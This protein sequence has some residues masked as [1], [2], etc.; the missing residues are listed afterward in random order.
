[1]ISFD[2]VFENADRYLAPVWRERLEYELK[3]LMAERR[4]G[5]LADWL[6]ALEATPAIRPQT[7]S[8][9]TPTVTLGTA[10]E[11][12]ESEKSQIAT[13][14]LAL[15]PWRKGPYSCFGNHIDTEWR[16]DWKWERVQPHIRPLDGRVVLDI[17]CG[18]GYHCWRMLGDGAR[19]VLGVDPSQLF[20]MQFRMIRHFAGDHPI[21]IVPLGIEHLPR[22]KPIFDTV[23]SMGVLYHRRSPIDHLLELRDFL[24]PGGELVLETLVIEDQDGMTLVPQDRYAQMRN[25]WFIPSCPTMETW[26]HRAG[27]TDIKLRDV[28]ITTT[29]EQRSTDWMT[30]QSL[31][32]FLDPTD[33]HKTIEGYP[34]PT[35][36]IW[37]A[38]RP[39]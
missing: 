7:V 9:N 22:T 2:T 8:L 19:Y 6:N 21:D 23:F 30:Y 27:F 34:S 16:S 17:G 24:K 11:C 4:H 25:V 32:D 36:A 13:Q 3:V 31:S 29:D 14:L 38:T 37:T 20:M 26:L 18:S 10:S 28:N 33:P 15:S 1:M 12:S 39:S 5:K 35:R